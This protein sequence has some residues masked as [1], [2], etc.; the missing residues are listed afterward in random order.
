MKI[1]LLNLEKYYNYLI[2]KESFEIHNELR[3]LETEFK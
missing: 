2:Y 1:C 3:P